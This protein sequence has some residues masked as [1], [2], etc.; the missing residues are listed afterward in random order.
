MVAGM[1][2]LLPRKGRNNKWHFFYVTIMQDVVTLEKKTMYE[3][4]S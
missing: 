3:M 1:E 2:E 4:T